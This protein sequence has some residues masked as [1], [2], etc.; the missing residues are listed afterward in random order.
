M[1]EVEPLTE[2]HTM[3]SQQPRIHLSF[4]VNSVALVDFQAEYDLFAAQAKTLVLLATLNDRVVWDLAQ[5]VDLA[6]A[7]YGRKT[8]LYRRAVERLAG[9]VQAHMGRP[10]ARAMFGRAAVLSRLVDK[11]LDAG[12]EAPVQVEALRAA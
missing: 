6:D 9:Y 7:G 4:G 3:T 2:A 10:S 11:V 12:A 8:A 1:P 5:Y